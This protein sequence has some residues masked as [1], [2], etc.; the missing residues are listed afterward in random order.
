ME[1]RRRVVDWGLAALLLVVPA[2]VLRTSLRA[3]EHVGTLD[4]AVLRV[5]SPLQSGVSYVV[6]GVGNLWSRYVAL[7]DV[8]QENRELRAENEKLRAELAVVTRQAVDNK[9]LE[10]MVEL[11]KRTPADTAGARVISAATSPYYRV[12]RISID[13]GDEDCK[14]PDVPCLKVAVGMPVMTS[15][16]LVGR[17]QKLYGGYSDVMLTTDAQSAVDVE[18]GRTGARGVLKGLG[19]SDAYLC[20]L[21]WVEHSS[22]PD[23][24]A[25][26]EVGDKVLTSGLGAAFPA[27]IVVGHVSKV[28]DKD[29]GMFQEVY[30]EPAVEFSHLRGVTVLLAPPPPPDPGAETKRRSE[31]AFGVRPF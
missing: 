12:V 6:D 18:I 11:K 7:V 23:A 8:E 14:N 4:Y 30:V 21:E 16:G 25:P 9:A 17:I 20:K 10:E 29:Y 13:R 3:P 24:A 27:G 31:S 28:I 19:Q 26:V 15:S 22:D 1:L 5:S 2:L